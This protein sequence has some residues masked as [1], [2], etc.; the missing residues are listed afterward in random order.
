MLLA[1]AC[2]KNITDSQQDINISMRASIVNPETK[3]L[4]SDAGDGALSVTWGGE[5]KLSVLTVDA[6]GKVIRN[7][8]LSYSGTS[9]LKTIT[10][11]GTV[12][13]KES[14]QEYLCVY[15]ALTEIDVPDV[16]M[17]KN[18]IESI[19]YDGN[20]LEY[21]GNY[22]NTQTASGNPGQ[23]KDLDLMIG[24]PVFV[25]TDAEVSLARQIGVL[26]LVL[27]INKLPDSNKPLD[28][29]AVM[30]MNMERYSF[31]TT[32]DINPKTGV[33]EPD[34]QQ[35]I[36]AN[37]SK[38]VSVGDQLIIYYPMAASSLK[39][40]DDYGYGIG[41]I[42]GNPED[43]TGYIWLT[44]KNVTAEVYTGKMTTIKAT[45]PGTGKWRDIKTGTPVD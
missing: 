14:G 16:G 35:A 31:N 32:I 42:F 10:F 28:V 5:E 21:D 29:T 7:Q 8:V 24:K 18:S 45:V 2:E 27:D 40:G 19:S 34:P 37:I 17:H 12:S 1:A 26:K 41:L 22:N 25:G 36:I 6:S 15:P 33:C 11:S 23:L 4:Y 44:N 20:K 38:T 9:G 43:E 13:A 30:L 3:T 39:A